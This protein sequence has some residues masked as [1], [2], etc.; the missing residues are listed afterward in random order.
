MLRWDISWGSQLKFL[1][2]ME[3]STGVTPRALAD[4]PLIRSHLAWYIESFYELSAGRDIGE[5]VPPLSAEEMLAYCQLVGLP[6]CRQ[7]VR[8]FEVV[9]Q[10][11][12]VYCQIQNEKRAAT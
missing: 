8:L 5:Y 1:Q 9:R 4:R 3:R 7:R 6:D 12:L 2:E 10:L 11:D